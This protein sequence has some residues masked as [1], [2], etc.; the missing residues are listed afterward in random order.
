[1]KPQGFHVAAIGAAGAGIQ[2]WR[3]LHGMLRNPYAYAPRAISP[4]TSLLSDAERRRASELTR[5]ALAAAEQACPSPPSGLQAVFVSH[6]GDGA[7]THAICESLASQQPA[8]SP[9]RFTNSVHNAPAAYWSIALGNVAAT[10]SICAG[11]HGFSAGL[12]E[13]MLVMRHSGKPVLLVVYDVPFPFPLAERVPVRQPLALGFYLT[14]N[15]S[16]DRWRLAL[17]DEKPEAM[18]SALAKYF[19]AHACAPALIWLAAQMRGESRR[20]VLPYMA[21]LSLALEAD[22]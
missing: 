12:I 9:I 16:D 8:I 21:G 5:L 15:G 11:E 14:P 18:P 17:T 10:T 1:M 22:D 2:S 4:K 20:S 19:D 3:D 13:A 7:I 6:T